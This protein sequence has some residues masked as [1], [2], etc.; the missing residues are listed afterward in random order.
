MNPHPHEKWR[1]IDIGYPHTGYGVEARTDKTGWV[2]LG[3]IYRARRAATKFKQSIT[4]KHGF[5]ADDLRVVTLAI[6]R[7]EGIDD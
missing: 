7:K 5:G 6:T 2:L 4:A 3:G 1:V